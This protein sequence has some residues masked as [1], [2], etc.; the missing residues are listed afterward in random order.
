[1]TRTD[2]N[3]LFSRGDLFS[4]LGARTRSVSHL[5]EEIPQD[6]FLATSVD[7]LVEHLVAKLAIDPLV[8]HEDQMAMEH[9][10]V[11]IDVTGRFEYG[12]SLDGRAILV[13]G[14]QLTF[15]LPFS[16]DPVES[17][18]KLGHFWGGSH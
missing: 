5:I 13:D 15:H 3:Y 12:G 16:G 4:S 1:M 10:E 7:T 18:R 2:R 8:L 14:H 9:S 11:K 17:Q 6:Q